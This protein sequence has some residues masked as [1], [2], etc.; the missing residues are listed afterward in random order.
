VVPAWPGS[1]GLFGS[2][3]EDTGEENTDEVAE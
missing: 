1:A 2:S 3:P